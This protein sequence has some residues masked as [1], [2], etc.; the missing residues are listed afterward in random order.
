MDNTYTHTN[1]PSFVETNRHF[2]KEY[3]AWNHIEPTFW[4]VIN[5]Y[6]IIHAG[7]SIVFVLWS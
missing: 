6:K 7:K 3:Y 4:T 1:V 5:D 2:N